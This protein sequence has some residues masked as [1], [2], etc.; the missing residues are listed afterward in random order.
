MRI[1][2]T[3]IDLVP[4]R[5][6]SYKNAEFNNNFV[7]LYSFIIILFCSILEPTNCKFENTGDG[8]NLSTNLLVFLGFSWR[9]LE[10]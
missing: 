1:K 2:Y 9:I 7:V 3:F 5:N 4:L 10:S 6:G 8:N